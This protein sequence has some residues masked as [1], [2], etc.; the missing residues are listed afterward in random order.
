MSRRQDKKSRSVTVDY[1]RAVA[2]AVF[3]G[4]IVTAL[5]MMVIAIGLSVADIPQ[6]VIAPAAIIASALGA[7]SSGYICSRINGERG[8]VL[9]LVCGLVIF[10]LL[11]ITGIAFVPSGGQS[12]AFI[13]LFAILV[14]AALGG[15]IGVNKR[16]KIK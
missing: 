2:S 4:I 15:I 16:K 6:K 3:F 11:F 13:K 5:I 12:M 8:F 9:G 10:A 7:F 1:V 14:G